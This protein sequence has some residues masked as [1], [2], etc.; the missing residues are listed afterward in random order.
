MNF[1]CQ[2]LPRLECVHLKRVDLSSVK[3]PGA[4]FRGS[5][6][7]YVDF[8]DAD[9]SDARFG[10]DNYKGEEICSSIVGVCLQGSNLA[11]AELEGVSVF[12]TDFSTA[13]ISDTSFE[14]VQFNNVIFSDKQIDPRRFDGRSLDSLKR[15]R[16]TELKLQ[17]ADTPCAKP[18]RQDLTQWKKKF[19]LGL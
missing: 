11:R 17:A 18:W 3:M 13:D 12:D 4:S 5:K 1:D 19:A 2:K 7:D 9:L 8:S 15:G 6:I 10:C 14:N 16:V